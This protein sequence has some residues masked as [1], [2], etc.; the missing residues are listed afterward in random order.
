MT[1][2]NLIGDSSDTLLWV[3]S[4]NRKFDSFLRASAMTATSDPDSSQSLIYQHT[5]CQYFC[6]L[7]IRNYLVLFEVFYMTL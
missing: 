2:A 7:L 3:T 1:D 6:N 5:L 4:N